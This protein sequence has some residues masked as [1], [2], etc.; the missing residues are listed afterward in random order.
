VRARYGQPV[1]ITDAEITTRM[2][3]RPNGKAACAGILVVNEIIIP[4]TTAK[5]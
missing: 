1:Q 2:G 4:S 3:E 5:T